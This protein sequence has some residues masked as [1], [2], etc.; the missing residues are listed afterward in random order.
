MSKLQE[1]FSNLLENRILELENE[2]EEFETN[3]S[4]ENLKLR[5]P[6]TTDESGSKIGFAFENSNFTTLCVYVNGSKIG[7]VALT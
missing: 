5:V 7:S 3:V 2:L 6:Y 1:A 4:E